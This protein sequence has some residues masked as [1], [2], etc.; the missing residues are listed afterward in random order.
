MSALYCEPKLRDFGLANCGWRGFGGILLDH[1]SGEYISQ[2]NLA[3]YWKRSVAPIITGFVE[4]LLPPDPIKTAPRRPPGHFRCDMD[5]GYVNNVNLLAARRKGPKKMGVWFVSENAGQNMIQEFKIKV[6]DGV[7]FSKHGI[8]SEIDMKDPVQELRTSQTIE[9]QLWVRCK[10]HLSVANPNTADVVRVFKDSVRCYEENVLLPGHVT[11]CDAN[12]MVWSGPI[13]LPLSRTKSSSNDIKA[14]SHSD[15]PRIV[16]VSSAYEVRTLDLR[17][18]SIL[19]STMVFSVPELSKRGPMDKVVYVPSESMGRPH[20]QHIRS[21]PEKPHNIFV[22]TTHSAYLCDDRFPKHPVLQL[23]HTIPY[24]SHVLLPT[25]PVTDPCGSGCII[26]VYLL[27]HLVTD[28]SVSHLYIHESNIWSAILPIHSVGKCSDIFETMNPP[29]PNKGQ[30][31]FNPIMGMDVVQGYEDNY[32]RPT[33]FLLRAS[34]DGSVWFQ[35]MRY[36]HI[37]SISLKGMWLSSR[38]RVEDFFNVMTEN[39]VC[40]RFLHND[41]I[42]SVFYPTTTVDVEFEDDM[43]PTNYYNWE[44]SGKTLHKECQPLESLQPSHPEAVLPSIVETVW[45][46]SIDKIWKF[47]GFRGCLGTES[48]GDASVYITANL[49]QTYSALLCLVILGDDLKGVDRAAVLE[50]VRKS[51]KDDGS[52]WSEGHGSESDMRFVFCAVSISHILQD[53]SCIK[54]S[55]LGSFIRSSLNYDGGIG[56]SPGDESH[57][58]STFCAIASLSL[59]NRL[60]DGSVLSSRDIERLVKWALWKQDQGFHGRANKA[61]DSCYAFWLGATLEILDAYHFVDKDKLRSFLLVAQN[62]QLGGFCKVPEMSE[63]PDLLHTYFSVAALSLLHEPGVSPINAS[64][65]VSRH[66][67]EHI[68]RLGT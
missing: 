37:D 53:Y 17:L 48:K 64:L 11:L 29:F 60:W 38:K 27:D 7:L 51:Q 55:L 30:Y 35:S 16:F 13:N 31:I 56:Q 58:G 23:P 5:S 49:A 14:L 26:S 15:H 1:N 43:H 22:I 6:K 18:D 20:I 68:R 54:W 62:E 52:F 21:L 24:G 63:S 61:D 46:K 9:N 42:Y 65:N 34:S 3:A 8:G 33:D 25:S 28:I 45:K 40:K 19:N 10:H 32:G 36:G 50:T 47:C 4:P 44:P 41:E 12:G 66:V 59:A 57:G 39:E 2:Y 67:Y